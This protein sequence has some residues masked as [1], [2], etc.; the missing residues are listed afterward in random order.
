MTIGLF[1]RDGGNVLR[2]ISELIIRDAGNVARTISE[3][4]IRD[5]T[6][7]PR[8]VFNP[9]G[10][11]TLTVTASPESV[12]RVVIGISTATT[13]TTTATPSGGTPPYAHLWTLTYHDGPAPPTATAPSGDVTA[14][15]QTGMFPDEA[16]TSEWLD[17]V[18]DDNG[19]TA[20]DTVTANFSSVS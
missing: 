8:L 9:S 4:W 17:T 2:E 16:Y 13:P 5:A 6:N 7:T 11:L 14:F 1:I 18:T 19:A 12:S 20:T 15:T 10:S 3:L